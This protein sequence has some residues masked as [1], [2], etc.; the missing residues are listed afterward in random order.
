MFSFLKSIISY[1]VIDLEAKLMPTPDCSFGG[2]GEVELEVFSSGNARMEI[3]IKHTVIPDGTPVDFV[4]NGSTF[5][6]VTPFRGYARERFSFGEQQ[7]YP[8]FAEGDTV[9]MRI[10]GQTCYTGTF[11]RD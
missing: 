2:K 1:Q 8:E 11:Y 10:A 6:T 7:V 4:Y 5:A 9:E 3:D